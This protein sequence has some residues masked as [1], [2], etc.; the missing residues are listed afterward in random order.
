MSA[1]TVHF[2]DVRDL[3]ANLLTLLFFLTPILFSLDC[4]RGHT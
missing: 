3:L 2:K 1:L 4:I